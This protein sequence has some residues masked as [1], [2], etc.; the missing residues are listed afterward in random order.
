MKTK[1]PVLNKKVNELEVSDEF[2]TLCD[3]KGFNTLEEILKYD[4]DALLDTYG[5]TMHGMMELVELLDRYKLGRIL[6]E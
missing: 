1:N 6:K 3:L 4:T 2:K 5:F